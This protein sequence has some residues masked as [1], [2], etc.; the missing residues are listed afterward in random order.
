MR[1]TL[2][3]LREV[4]IFGLVLTFF[5]NA[6]VLY[7]DSQE[8][9]LPVTDFTSSQELV[10]P[11]VGTQQLTDGSQQMLNGTQQL[12]GIQ[13]PLDD[14]GIKRMQFLENI[15][16]EI[17]TTQKDFSDITH[18]V[19][20]TSNQLDGVHE[21]VTTLSDQ[22]QNLDDQMAHTES[23]VNNVAMQIGEK[24]NQLLLI[25]D[26]MQVKK[27]AIENQKQMLMEYLNVIYQQESS[28]TNTLTNN[29]EINVAKLLLSDQSVGDQ[30]QQ[31]KYF[32]IL[33]D[34]GHRI[35]DRLEQ[36]VAGL[37]RDEADLVN[38]KDRLAQLYDS[39]N[40]EKNNLEVQRQ[41]KATL[42]EQTQG[43][44]KIYQQLLEESKRQQEQAQQ[45][46]QTLND[47]LKFI[48]DK[49]KEL[50]DDFNPDDYKD[51]FIGDTANVYSFI[52]QT[53]NDP[54]GFNPRW[55]VSPSRGISAYFHDAAYVHVFGVAHQAIDIREPQGTVIHAPADGVVYKVKDNGYGYS[56][57]IIA[58]KGGFM[59]VYGHVSEFKVKP[60]EKVVAGEAVGLTGGT[61]G[62]KGAGLMTTGAHLHF[63]V[64]KGGKH[65]DPLDYLPLTYLPIDSLPEKYQSRITGDK[66]KVS[67][68]TQEE[69]TA[70][71]SADLTRMVEMGDPGFLLRPIATQ[72]TQL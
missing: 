37:H 60:G 39:L 68:T 24:E 14:R 66:I 47:N 58:H 27:L 48:E 57:L 67:R 11:A 25:Y 34:Q 32:N 1:K 28:M 22:L 62:S 18:T 70:K 31:I 65:V 64:L 13:Q 43:Q 69:D 50:G 9:S 3:I 38:R 59:T 41:A 29:D 8:G 45:D 6:S 26:E 72:E 36:L 61:P 23:M 40:I 42:L 35:F 55:P 52:Q 53:E 21:K 17:R 30:L 71:N 51:L 15:R 16:G 49:V 20:D 12:D 54:D 19:A 10:A 4:I 56:Y 5:V 44:E 33:T 2:K 46:L 7:A 63:E